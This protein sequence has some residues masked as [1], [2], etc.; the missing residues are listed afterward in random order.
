MEVVSKTE[1]IQLLIISKQLD[2]VNELLSNLRVQGLQLNAHCTD[3]YKRLN[4][5]LS[6]RKWHL[7]IFDLNSS[8]SV[9]DFIR[10]MTNSGADL[11]LIIMSEAGSKQ[12]DE[13][14]LSEPV[15]DI[16]A[17]D[18]EA[19]VRF[20]IRREV[21]KQALKTR[22]RLLKLN[23]RELEKRHQTLLDNTQQA[24]AYILEGMH[25]YCNQSYAELFA[26]ESAAALEKTPLLDLFS[27]THRDALKHLLCANIHEEKQLVLELAGNKVSLVFSPVRVGEQN[28]LQLMIG[29]ASGNDSYRQK[30][31]S[32]KNRDLLTRLYNRAFFQE[33]IELAIAGAIKHNQHYSLIIVQV[34]EFLD[35]KSAIG[36][37]NAN[38]LLRDI[39]TFLQKS[40]KKQ[41]SAARLSEYEFALLLAECPLA[42]AIELADFIKSKINTRITSTALPSLQLSSSIGI[43]V[44]NNNALDAEDSITRARL[45]MS[46]KLP[47][48]VGAELESFHAT[49]N[50]LEGLLTS[51]EKALQKR[52]FTLL[53]QPMPGLQDQGSK[54]YEVLSRL[55]DPGG[56]LIS[57]ST[58][59]P[60]ANLNGMGDKLDR[61]IIS[62]ACEAL[63]RQHTDETSRLIINLTSNSL[64]SLTFIPWLADYLHKQD[65]AQDRLLFQ[66]SELSICNCPDHCLEF[67][68]GLDEMGI[69]YI[70]C[71]YGCVIEPEK[72][73]SAISPKC[74]KLDCTLVRD[75]SDNHYQLEDLKL[76]INDLHRR[77][78]KVIVPQ[79]EDNTVLPHLWKAGVDYVQGYGLEKPSQHMNYEFVHNHEISLQTA[80][81]SS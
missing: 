11:P 47:S 42:E 4:E 49:G 5:L 50:D 74:V 57:P 39:A 35:I 26:A 18:D 69:S 13:R 75:I 36:L 1:L 17:F 72:Y 43:A 3:T 66:I 32:I 56:V 73:L 44:I 63:S 70:V 67:C 9:Q 28:C 65:I 8:I 25:L 19:H 48:T 29:V 20:A 22:Y 21:N 7:I 45:N 51:L 79:I 37:S 46:R 40:V 31:R 68:H 80:G 38:L 41:F 62:L 27:D 60:L 24:L 15:Q 71:H 10:V 64:A 2:R 78:F 54:Y 33:K 59:I 16:I 34:N 6:C 52:S 30:R 12:L 76:L 53:F 55:Q 14:L 61:L 58:Y 81:Q 23:H 77:G